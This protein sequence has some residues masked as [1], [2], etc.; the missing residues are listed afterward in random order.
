MFGY[1]QWARCL[2]RDRDRKDKIKSEQIEQTLV[3]MEKRIEV[4]NAHKI[5]GEERL[6][7]LLLLSSGGL[8]VR[9]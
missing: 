1:V 8:N 4:C 9:R 3:T 2:E 5:I 6:A 7:A